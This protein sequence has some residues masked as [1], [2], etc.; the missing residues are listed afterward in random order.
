MTLFPSDPHALG[1][2]DL[3]PMTGDDVGWAGF[4]LAGLDPWRTL[5]YQ[6]EGL[7]A[8][9]RRPDPSLHRFTVVAGGQR[10]GV[11]CLRHPWLRG[12]YIELLAVTLPGR[13]I[14]AALVRWTSERTLAE[15][16]NLWATVSNFNWPARAFYHAQGFVEASYLPDLVGAGFSEILLRKRLDA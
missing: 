2:C 11:L 13:G 15:A 5:G 12:P 9:L 1:T 4:V 10:A 3:V 16:T 7:S 6:A 14:G 8:Y